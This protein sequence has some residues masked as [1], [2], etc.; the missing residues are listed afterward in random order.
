MS[1]SEKRICLTFI[2]QLEPKV[3]I[4][5]IYRGCFP[6]LFF[7]GLYFDLNSFLL[8]KR[9]RVIPGISPRIWYASFSVM[10]RRSFSG[11]LEIFMVNAGQSDKQSGKLFP[12]IQN[13]HKCAENRQNNA[14][15][16]TDGA[17]IHFIGKLSGNNRSGSGGYDAD[18]QHIPAL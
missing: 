7:G 5:I 9:N 2:T 16:Q 8:K 13:Q 17:V 18:K 14:G 6:W 3:E 1:Q 12:I 11:G 4:L 10:A 15:Y